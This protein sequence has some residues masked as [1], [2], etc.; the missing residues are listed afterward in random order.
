[1][2]GGGVASGKKDPGQK[3]PVPASAPANDRWNDDVPKPSAPKP[4]AKPSSARPKL[5]STANKPSTA[6]P[7]AEVKKPMK[8]S[9]DEEEDAV[10]DLALVAQTWHNLTQNCHN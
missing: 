9:P 8:K 7:V 3:P 5:S 1:M 4:T 2:S 6:A 10:E